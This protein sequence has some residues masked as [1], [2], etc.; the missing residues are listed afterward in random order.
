M[1]VSVVSGWESELEMAES[2]LVLKN[3]RICFRASSSF[4]LG[5]NP[6]LQ[7]CSSSSDQGKCNK[8]G[9]PSIRNFSTTLTSHILILA[10][11]S[12]LPMDEAYTKPVSP[13]C[14]LSTPCYECKPKVRHFFDKVFI[15]AWFCWGWICLFCHMTSVG[16][17]EIMVQHT[18]SIICDFHLPVDFSLDILFPCIFWFLHQNW[19]GAG[20]FTLTKLR[21]VGDEEKTIPSCKDTHSPMIDPPVLQQS[22]FCTLKKTD[23]PK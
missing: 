3:A 8:T 5:N 9:N 4:V 18:P 22:A 6:S 21:S 2:H 19:V 20:W 16:G 23:W 10:D 12:Y 1:A 14:R 7:I 11:S 17:L 15:K 13:I